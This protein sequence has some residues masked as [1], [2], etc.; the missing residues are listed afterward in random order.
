MRAEQR[1]QGWQQRASL[2]QPPLLQ[3]ILKRCVEGGGVEDELGEL[4]SS[5]RVGAHCAS[6]P[7]QPRRVDARK[8]FKRECGAYQ[9]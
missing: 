4:S 3:V 5:A 6:P 7:A 9:S 8:G 2:S 1:C